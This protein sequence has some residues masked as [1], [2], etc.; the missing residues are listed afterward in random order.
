M[1]AARLGA[2]LRRRLS[3]TS[4]SRQNYHNTRYS[5][6]DTA[7]TSSSKL[8]SGARCH[9]PSVADRD[10]ECDHRLSAL[11]ALVVEE[12][13]KVNLVSRQGGARSSTST[14]S[15]SSEKLSFTAHV[16][17]RHVLDSLSLL[18][19]IDALAAAELRAKS[20]SSSSSSRGVVGGGGGLRVIDIGCG[21]GFP[22]LPLAITRP[23]HSFVLVDATKKKLRFV[24]RAVEHLG[25]ENVSVQCAR[26]E[27]L[28][29]NRRERE[30]SDV[31]VCRALAPLPVL[32]ELC[33][34]LIRGGGVLFA[35]KGPRG[36]R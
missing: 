35:L 10:A 21:G 36:E 23:Q 24:E 3:L 15:S 7:S 19:F 26:A 8:A 28:G 27:A 2:A 12:N 4:P 13:D 34:P 17:E 18:P 33:L 6:S 1:A 22:S 32:A 29:R 20:S 31:A 5:N 30:G 9:P 25:M 16:M 11:A 14:T